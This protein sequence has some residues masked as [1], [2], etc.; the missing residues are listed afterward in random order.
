MCR[1]TSG[2]GAGAG[3]NRLSRFQAKVSD[4]IASGLLPHYDASVL[5]IKRTSSKAFTYTPMTL[6]GLTAY[7]GS[8][9]ERG[10]IGPVTEWQA[11]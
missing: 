3:R 11:D 9:G 1:S 4:L 7:M 2:S 10:G 8:T 6:A 5:D